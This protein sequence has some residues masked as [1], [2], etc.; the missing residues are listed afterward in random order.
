MKYDFE[1]IM[2]RHGKDALAVDGIGEG[3]APDGPK[4]GFDVI[5]MWVADMNFPTVP[6]VCEAIEERIKHP[7]F[8]YFNPRDEY[9]ESIIKWQSIRNGERFTGTPMT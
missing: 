4:E 5:P 1:S 3:F 2:D 7:A 8:G 6:T 9:F